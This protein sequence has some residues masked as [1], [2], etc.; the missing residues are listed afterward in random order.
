MKLTIN[1]KY[2]EPLLSREKILATASFENAVPARNDVL[3]EIASKAGAKAEVVLVSSI[4]PSFGS[5]KA[6]IV[7][8][9]YKS[10]EALTSAVPAKIIKKT[11]LAEKKEDK[12]EEAPA[13]E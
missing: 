6:E 1:K 8:Y 10:K 2:E 12:K 5:K 11:G 13:A 3:N 4:K 7:A 9:V